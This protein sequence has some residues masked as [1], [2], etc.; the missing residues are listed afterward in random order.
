[1]DGAF[2]VYDITNHVSFEHTGKWL[3]EIRNAYYDPIILL[4]G[5]K[6]DMDSKR[7]VN[8]VEAKTF[9]GEHRYTC[10]LFPFD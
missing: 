9:A 10:N 7:E 6:T 8:T 5:N 2:L 4:V 3:E 1:M